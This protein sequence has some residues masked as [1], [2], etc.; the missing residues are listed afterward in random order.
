MFICNPN[1]WEVDRFLEANIEFDTYKVSKWQADWFMPNQLGIVRVGTD[2]RT[3]TQLGSRS[4]L[5]AGIYAIVRVLSKA[6]VRS[7]ITSEQPGK[8]YWTDREKDHSQDFVVELQ[9]LHNLLHNPVLLSDLA[10]IPEVDENLIRGPQASS[11]PLDMKT[12]DIVLS[13]TVIEKTTLMSSS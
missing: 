6:K 5:L 7:E 4:K 13:L 9:Y 12:F 10:N 1:Y 3:K 11:Y 2:Q 8:V